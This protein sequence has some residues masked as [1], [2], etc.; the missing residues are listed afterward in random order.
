M[1]KIIDFEQWERKEH[2]FF[3]NQF[4]DPSFEITTN[5]DCTK[6]YQKTKEKNYSFFLYYLHCSLRAVNAVKEFK[7]RIEDEKVIIYD[8]IHAGPTIARDNGTFGFSHLPYFEDFKEFA[9]NAEK[10]IIEV[11]AARNLDPSFNHLDVIHFSS[12]PWISFTSVAHPKFSHKV[13]D[14]VPKISIGKIN[15]KDS[16]KMMPVSVTANHALMDGYHIGKYL[17]LFQQYLDE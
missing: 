11:K 7:L 10:I 8:T 2:F 1:K 4:D 9:N 12:I 16:K 6:A 5:V 13:K 17:E 15:E 3:F 14:S